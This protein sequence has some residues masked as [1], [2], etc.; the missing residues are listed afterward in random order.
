MAEGGGPEGQDWTSKLRIGDD[1]DAEDVCQ[2]RPAVTAECSKDQVLA[3]LVED[4]DSAEH[5]GRSKFIA[6]E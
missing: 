1:L 3:L 2:S 4:E 6:V 5:L